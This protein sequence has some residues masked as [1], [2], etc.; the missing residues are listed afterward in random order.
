MLPWPT[1]RLK[2]GLQVVACQLR[3]RM[4][5][6]TLKDRRFTALRSR[7][8]SRTV[9]QVCSCQEVL[10]RGNQRVGESLAETSPY[11][12]E[13]AVPASAWQVSSQPH[14]RSACFC[15]SAAPAAMQ[16]RCM[17]TGHHARQT[18]LGVL[19]SGCG[20]A[21]GVRMLRRSMPMGA[22]GPVEATQSRHGAV[23]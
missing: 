5:S 18:Y 16:R 17:S 3:H 9:C 20:V 6:L 8:A 1:Q 2:N 12:Q 4:D 22:S 21:P 14:V 23:N 7:L 19:A 11:I 15:P 13:C 10:L